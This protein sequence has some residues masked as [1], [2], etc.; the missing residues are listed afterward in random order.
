MFESEHI[1]GQ[2]GLFS[3]GWHLSVCF[4][5]GLQ[6]KVRL[7]ASQASRRAIPVLPPLR[8]NSSL[9][10]IRV[11]NCQANLANSCLVALNLKFLLFALGIFAPRMAAHR[12]DKVRQPEEHPASP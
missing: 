1:L 2:P 7:G 12:S 6:V 9:A 11:A 8:R 10:Y 5:A 3:S 4:C